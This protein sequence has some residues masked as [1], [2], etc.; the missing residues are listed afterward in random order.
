M[1]DLIKW[2]IKCERKEDYIKI[3]DALYEDN[4]TY[5]QKSPKKSIKF[6]GDESVKNEVDNLILGLNITKFTIIDAELDKELKKQKN[7][8]LKQKSKEE[9]INFFDKMSKKLNLN[10]KLSKEE[11]MRLVFEGDKVD[12]F[13]NSLNNEA[14]LKD[15]TTI[16]QINEKTYSIHW[17]EDPEYFDNSEFP[18]QPIEVEKVISWQPILKL[19]NHKD[20]NKNNYLENYDECPAERDEL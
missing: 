18:N 11:L 6:L 7:E 13:V 8:D 14:S 2:K 1:S 3:A 4:F 12:E 10:M 15:I 9:P 19:D 5:I 20:Y 17:K 16:L